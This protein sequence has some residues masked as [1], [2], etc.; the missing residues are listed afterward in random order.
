[1][2]PTDRSNKS[3][4]IIFPTGSPHVHMMVWL[5]GAPKIEEDIAASVQW[6]DQL[7]SCNVNTDGIIHQQHRHT[8]SCQRITKNGTICR[9]HIPY[10]PMRDTCIL[11]PYGKEYPK[12]KKGSGKEAIAK[13]KLY[14]ESN[15]KNLPEWSFEEFLQHFSMDE[16]EYI[17]ALRCT[18]SRPTVFLKRDIKSCFTNCYIKD[19]AKVWR[20]NM[21]VQPIVDPYGVARYIASYMTKAS[22]GISNLMRETSEQI[23]HGDLCVILY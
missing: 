20:S 13:I 21:D 22:G 12:S 19:L 2:I 15:K 4:S 10:P 23:K 5:E 1:M 9:F 18:I 7:I 17:A 3:K 6:I 14:I 16:K 11:T 8:K